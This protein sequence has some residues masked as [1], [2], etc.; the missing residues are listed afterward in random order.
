MTSR[1]T[2]ATRCE[3]LGAALSLLLLLL[4][5]VALPS[6]AIAAPSRMPP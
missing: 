2:S 4:A 1:A 5:L 6:A 3:V